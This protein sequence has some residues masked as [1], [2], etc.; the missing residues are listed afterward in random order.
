MGQSRSKA[1]KAPAPQSPL[2]APSAGGDYQ[3]YPV[4]SKKG[5]KYYHP[6]EKVVTMDCDLYTCCNASCYGDLELF[7]RGC[8][9]VSSGSGCY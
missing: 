3:D 4:P 1:K 5:A 7:N 8:T 2:Y 9:E 6:G